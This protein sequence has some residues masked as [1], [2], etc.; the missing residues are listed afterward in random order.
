MSQSGYADAD[1]LIE[2]AFEPTLPATTL[3]AIALRLE[4]EADRGARPAWRIAAAGRLRHLWLRRTA[5]EVKY[6]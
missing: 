4:D 2:V 6:R 1:A 5:S 3:L